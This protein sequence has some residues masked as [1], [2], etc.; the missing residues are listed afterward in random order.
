MAS[1]T[2]S[3]A[4]PHWSNTRHRAVFVLNYEVLEV[5]QLYFLSFPSDKARNT[6]ELKVMRFN[7]M[8]MSK[9]ATW[10][11]KQKTLGPLHDCRCVKQEHHINVYVS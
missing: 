8:L 7:L 1:A 6:T 5:K 4:A 2:C 10:Q 11:L 3:A 9:C